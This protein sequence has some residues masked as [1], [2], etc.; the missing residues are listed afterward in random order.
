MNRPWLQVLCAG[1]LALT[2]LLAH[3]QYSWLDDKGTRVF[4]DRPPPP[5]TPPARILKAPH[6]MEPA[7]LAP[8]ADTAQA[9]MPDWKLREEDYKKRSAQRA[10]EE[11][12]EQ[13]ALARQR[14]DHI[15]E[16]SWARGAQMQLARARWLE[17][18]N[19]KGKREIMS[20]ADRRGEQER[21]QKILSH[22]V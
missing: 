3:A 16:C 20:E 18:T 22:C 17:W 8:A 12:K 1:A 15:V 21:A 4:S 13:Q 14:G 19:K 9:A 7:P 10:R 11:E 2:S 6:G 5:G